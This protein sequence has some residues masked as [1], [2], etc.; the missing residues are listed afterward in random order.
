[1]ERGELARLLGA[2]SSG[3]G[4]ESRVVGDDDPGKFM[5]AFATA[6]AGGGNVFLSSPSWGTAERAE[7]ARL[8]A[9]QRCGDRGWLLIPSGGAGG[10]IR[11]ARHD[12]RTVAAAVNGFCSHFELGPVNS[13][14]V[15]PLHHVSGF[16]AWMR[17]LLTA[18]RFIPCPWKEIESGRFP[19]GLPDD[20]CISLVPTQLQR[21]MA[22][23]RAVSWLR[24]FRAILVGGGPL[25]DGLVEEAAR[26]RLPLAP[27]YGA[28]ETA[29][30]VTALRPWQ[31]L[32]GQRGCGAALPHASIRIVD[33]A[34]TITGDSVF[35][36]YFPGTL[37]GRSWDSGDLGFLDPSGGLVILGRRD[38]TILTGGK[39][40]SPDEVEAALRRSGEF[41]D[42]AVVGIPDAE[43]GQMVV[44]CHPATGRAPS[45][46][47]LAAALAPLESFKHPKRYAG[48]S[49]WPRNAQGKVNRAALARL[50]A[51]P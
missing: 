20:C 50:A 21:L 43:W 15:L 51:S 46:A 40:V 29:A 42:V 47:K 26:L 38:G 3:A 44:A 16:M 32:S 48:I 35:R 34:V 41:D 9:N 22:S 33:G 2:A 30:M 8:A 45:P 5:R 23:G 28:T 24:E 14:C 27:S 12:G 18:G 39:K 1:M 31:F 11:F 19:A 49:P 4:G 6:V 37:R 10:R 13:V 17:S 36:G 25:W 7:L